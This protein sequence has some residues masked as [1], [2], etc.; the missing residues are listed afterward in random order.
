MKGI[1]DKLFIENCLPQI[2][3]KE[4]LLIEG[5]TFGHDVGVALRFGW[6]YITEGHYGAVGDYVV[7]KAKCGC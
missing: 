4:L 6:K 7:N 2:D 3:Q 5:G 1:S